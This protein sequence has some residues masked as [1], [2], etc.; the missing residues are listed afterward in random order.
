MP[1]QVPVLPTGNALTVNDNVVISLPF[2]G[3]YVKTVY[4]PND[5]ISRFACKG[6]LNECLRQYLIVER[7]LDLFFDACLACVDKERVVNQE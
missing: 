2:A 1:F 7:N 4:A 5:H 3:E 6:N